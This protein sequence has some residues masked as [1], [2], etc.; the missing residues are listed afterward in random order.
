[1]ASV[2]KPAGSRKYVI[3]WRDEN[4][5]RHKRTGCT[6]KAE[7]LRIGNEL[8]NQKALR[9]AG[10][11]DRKAEKYRDHEARPLAAHLAD[12]EAALLHKGGT[13]RHAHVTGYR[14]GRV[15]ELA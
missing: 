8:E 1:M 3:M 10:L 7:S 9:R 12:F 4:G 15:L 5:K 14:A 11:V 6:D 13:K 2:F